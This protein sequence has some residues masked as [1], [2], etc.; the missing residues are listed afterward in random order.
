MALLAA[1]GWRVPFDQEA[2]QEVGSNA[3]AE[4][5]GLERR[6]VGASRGFIGGKGAVPRKEGQRRTCVC[7]VTQSC[8]TLHDPTDCSPSGFSVH[9]IF[10]AR[11][12]E[13]VAISKQRLLGPALAGGFFTTSATW[14][15]ARRTGAREPSGAVRFRQGFHTRALGW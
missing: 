8:L 4:P 2:Q 15:E 7:S 6:A 11:V 12:L 5:T 3:A 14:R 13:Q 1:G 9:G 10:Q